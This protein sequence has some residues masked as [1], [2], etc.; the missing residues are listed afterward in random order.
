MSN[1][2]SNSVCLSGAWRPLD[3]HG[4]V[5]LETA[6]NF[7]LL[8]VGGFAKKNMFVLAV[9]SIQHLLRCECILPL[10]RSASDSDKADQRVGQMIYLRQNFQDAFQGR[11]DS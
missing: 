1:K 2:V 6:C 9:R 7:Q 4:V 11:A 8:S 10:I 5:P 3:Q